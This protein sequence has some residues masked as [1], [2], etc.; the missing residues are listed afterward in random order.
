MLRFVCGRIVY[1]AGCSS[2]V[3]AGF[4]RQFGERV[5][6][7][8][9][10]KGLSQEAMADAAGLHRT[11]I[12]LIERGQRSVRLETVER[13]ALALQVQPAEIMPTIPLRRR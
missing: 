13:L 3:A 9:E 10:E 1:K 12:S 5:R 8:R 4:V 6:V 7:L 11:H 2:S